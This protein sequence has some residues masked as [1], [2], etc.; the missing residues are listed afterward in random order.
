[1]DGELTGIDSEQVIAALRAAVAIPAVA[2]RTAMALADVAAS[3]HGQS[4]EVRGLIGQQLSG[5][6]S[7]LGTTNFAPVINSLSDR[8]AQSAFVA[9]VADALPVGEVVN[10]I[11][12]A[13]AA[14]EQQMSHQIL[15]IMTKLSMLTA[16]QGDETGVTQFRDAARELVNHWT[17]ADPNPTEHVQLLDRI[18][19]VERTSVAASHDVTVLGTSVVETSRIVQMALEL[20]FAGED[21]AAA[22]D[23]LA[24]S[25]AA[26]KLLEWAKAAGI[27]RTSKWLYDI[28][29][30]EKAIRRLLLTEP[31]DRLKARALLEVV[32]AS[33]TDVL[34]DVLER[35]EAR[36]T[37]MIV[38]QRLAEFGTEITPVLMA[39][40]ANAPWFLVRNILTLL[41]ELEEVGNDNNAGDLLRLLEHPQVQVRTEAVRVLLRNEHTRDAALRRALRDESDRVVILAIQSVTE[42]AE[43]GERPSQSILAQLPALVDTGAQSDPV[44]ARA[45]RAVGSVHRD[46]LRDWLVRLVSKRTPFL[47]R[48]K[49]VEP[50]QTAATALQALQRTYGSDPAVGRVLALASRSAQDLRWQVRE[51]TLERIQ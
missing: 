7:Q 49:L 20:D 4:P 46:D 23:S 34:L 3:A 42:M 18:A 44:R 5:L 17:L 39:R 26:P 1:V 21:T 9:D 2:R 19:S 22:A 25:G 48:L 14:T 29:V 36:G 27:S 45:V 31:V 10:W 16:A 47:R 50:T 8:S 51:S 43:E 38:R 33:S 40:L 13:A 24:E 41:Q 28:A 12:S 35:A 37:R 30:S 11:R 6:L 32:P 15:R